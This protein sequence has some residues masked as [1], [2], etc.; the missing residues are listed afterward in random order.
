VSLSS[1]VAVYAATPTLSFSPSGDGNN[2]T[3]NVIGDSNTPVVMYYLSSVNATT[4]SI[5]LGSTDINGSFS[6]MVSTSGY[7]INSSQPVYVLLNGYQSASMHWPYSVTSS[8]SLSLSQTNASLTVGQTVSITAAGTGSYY[9]S[10]N[11][12]SAASV[13]I[14]G[15]TITLT[16][17]SI[18][19]SRITVCQSSAQCADIVVTVNGTTQNSTSVVIS[20]TIS[21]GQTLSFA[22]SG[23]NSTYY[24]SSV[25]NTTFSALVSGSALTVTGLSI[26]NGSV[27]ICTSQGGCTLLYITVNPAV[28]SPVVT[29]VVVTPQ[30]SATPSKYM[31]LN[32]LKFGDTSNEVIELQKRLKE[33]GYFTGSY[34]PHFG[35]ST[36]A[37]IKRY[38]KGHGL[39]ALGNLGPATRQALNQ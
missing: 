29:P 16:G 31:F 6:G 28:I 3:V 26:G 8:T 37:S 36:V 11:T 34:S 20:P 13:S 5:T 7:G 19:S 30:I 24:A 23:S 38:Q 14:S 27:N 4:Q 1:L 22:L 33:E 18:G 9:V 25:S 2:V 17:V 10:T 12:G 32:P 35:N 39:T 21:V 15:P